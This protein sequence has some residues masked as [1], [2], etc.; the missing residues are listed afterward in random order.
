MCVNGIPISSAT[1]EHLLACLDQIAQR[2]QHLLDVDQRVR[3]VDLVEVDGVDLQAA[4][5]VLQR[6]ELPERLRR[7]QSDPARAEVWSWYQAACQTIPRA[8][9]SSMLSTPA[10]LPHRVRV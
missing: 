5:R 2:R 1:D 3:A 8:S 7:R 10:A 6:R 9:Y 4:Q